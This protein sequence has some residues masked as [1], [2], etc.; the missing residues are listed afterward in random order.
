[1]GGSVGSGGTSDVSGPAPAI[2][3]TPDSGGLIDVSGM[4]FD[5]LAAVIGKNSLGQALDYILASGQNG[6]GYHGFNNHIPP[7]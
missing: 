3:V 6:C 7:R 1:M 5:Q 2:V 4:T